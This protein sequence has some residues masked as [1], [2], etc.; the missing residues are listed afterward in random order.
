M[1]AERYYS[2]GDFDSASAIVLTDQE[3]HHLVH[4]MR[5]K[6]GDW[7]EIVNG[8]GLLAKA[9]IKKI[10]RKEV[11]LTVEERIES[12]KDPFEIILAQA[13]PRHQHL[14]FILEKGTELG[15]TQIW[16]FPGERSEKEKLSENQFKRAEGVLVASMKQCG[17][18]W[19]PKIVEKPALKQWETNDFPAFFGDVEP[20]AKQFASQLREEKLDR[21]II[22]FVGPEGGFT[23]H[24]TMI[25][26]KL[27]VKGVRLH[28]HILRTETAAIAA[29]T[30]I[31]SQHS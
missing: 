25:F 20:G 3:Y 22:F 5:G 13:L 28:H 8:L 18:L 15:M 17:R 2:K 10:N 1:P 7:V 23:D 30:L 4:V 12:P 6:E 29:L 19:L 21:G 27:G 14:D 9:K 24:E 31:S 26:K 16:L 11:I